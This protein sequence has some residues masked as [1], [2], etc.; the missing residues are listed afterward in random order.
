MS[1]AVVRVML[2]TSGVMAVEGA[3]AMA[4]PLLLLLTRGTPHLAAAGA[5]RHRPP[6]AAAP[7]AG[8]PSQ[9]GGDHC[10]AGCGRGGV[11][12]N[13]GGLAATR[14]RRPL[15]CTKS[16]Q[17]DSSGHVEETMPF[18]HHSPWGRSRGPSSPAG[19]ERRV[20]C[21]GPAAEEG[22]SEMTL[23]SNAAQEP[24]YRR[25][26]CKSGCAS[27]PRPR[28]LSRSFSGFLSGDGWAPSSKTGSWARDWDCPAWTISHMLRTYGRIPA[29]GSRCMSCS[30]ELS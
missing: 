2:V 6:P 21:P 11:V 19:T 27:L 9:R 30:V 29:C 20:G 22:P 24:V 3:V 14:R 10:T 12:V 1:P 28:V 13:E 18:P 16:A 25:R 15:P 23:E 17:R 8:S 7:S 26:L 5:R 4:A